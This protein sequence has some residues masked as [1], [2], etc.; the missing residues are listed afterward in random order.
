MLDVAI[1]G[2]GAAGLGAAKT[3]ISKGLSFKVLEAAPFIGGRAR[4]DTKSLGVPFDLGCRS[5]YGG[6]DN[7][8]Q[9]YAVENEVRLESDPENIAFHDGHRFLDSNETKATIEAFERFELD[10]V[11]AHKKLISTPG[12]PDRSQLEAIDTD[13]P[14]ADYFLQAM[15]LECTAPAKEISLAD[16][17]HIVLTSAGKAVRDGY[18]AMIH[19]VADGVE[20]VVDCPVS[21]IDLSGSNIVLDTPKGQ[22][23]TR[24]VVV[25]V[26]TAVLAAERIALRPGGW[27]NQKLTAIESLPLGSVTQ[28]GIRLK[29]GAIPAEFVQRQ[30]ETISSA[31]INCLMPEPQ[32]L[33]WLLGAGNGD[34]AIAYLGG[35]F[36]RELALQGEEAQADWAIQQ[37]SVLFGNSIK[38]S[39]IATCTTPFDR[40]PWIGGGYSYCRYGTGNQRPALAE[41]IEDRLFFAGEACS[42]D[43]PGTAHGAWLSGVATIEHISP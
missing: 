25:T 37:L 18:G 38:S 20:V 16:S 1:I 40:E 28:L 30:G 19:R 32:N 22:V 31:L 43:H 14:G 33:S 7:P 39:V 12:V 35:A 6:D 21:A 17:M 2:A 36:S 13:S 23:E 10:M 3:A 5:L 41:P 34:L 11:N 24:T 15:H 26:S 29:S 9:A 27:P 42:P 8:F 4:T